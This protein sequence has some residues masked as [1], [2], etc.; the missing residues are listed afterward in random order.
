MHKTCAYPF[1]PQP[2]ITLITIWAGPSKIRVLLL[3]TK[4]KFNFFTKKT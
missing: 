3:K 2:I 4:K 1:Q